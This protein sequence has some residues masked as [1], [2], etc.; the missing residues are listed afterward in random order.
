MLRFFVGKQFDSSGLHHASVWPSACLRAI[1]DTRRK[2][3]IVRTFSAPAYVMLFAID[4]MPFFVCGVLWWFI[5][6]IQ[7][8][9]EYYAALIVAGLAL[10]AIRRLLLPVRR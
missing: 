10:L 3:Y 5:L 6:R 2:A 8:V 4:S 1:D 7:G 9:A